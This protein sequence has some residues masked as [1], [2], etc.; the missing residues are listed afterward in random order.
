M[1]TRIREAT[2][3][4]APTIVRLTQRFLEGSGYG[5]ILMFNPKTLA[6]LILLLLAQGQ[7]VVF[8][9]ERRAWDG[10]GG[11]QAVGMLAAIAGRHPIT[12]EETVEELA[13]W[14][15]PEA[16]SSRLGYQ[17]LGSLEAWARHKACRMLKLVAPAGS[18]VGDFYTRRGYLPVET[19]YLKRL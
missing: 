15:N 9:G 12:G 18:R 8:L 10:V 7:G 14:V 11:W 1:S 6:D 16:R 3:A 2:V 19:A 4:D 17:M 13:W 5:Q